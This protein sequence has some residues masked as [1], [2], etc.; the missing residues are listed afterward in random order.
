MSKY[1]HLLSNIA[2]ALETAHIPYVVIG[3]QAVLVYGDPRFTRDID[4]TLGVDIDQLDVIQQVAAELSLEPKPKD[5]EGF[6]RQTNVYPVKEKSTNITVDFIFSFSPFETEMMRR[7]R[8]IEIDGTAV[9]YAS[10]EDVVVL[11][12]AAGRPLDI[13]DAKGIL[14]ANQGYD[15]EYILRWL[16]GFS[17]AVG[18]DLVQEYHSLVETLPK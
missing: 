13:K 5:V 15:E 16:Q 9:R 2:R 3:G 18:R 10:V 14:N 6:V 7:A 4:I 11:K 8:K 17:D 1:R 12:L